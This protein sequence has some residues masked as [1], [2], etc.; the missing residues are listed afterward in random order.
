MAVRA[1][2]D[3]HLGRT[4][5][6]PSGRI[7]F[8]LKHKDVEPFFR[9]PGGGARLIF[10]SIHTPSGGQSALKVPSIGVLS[11]RDPHKK[12]E[13]IILRFGNSDDSNFCRN[14]LSYSIAS[15]S[16]P[17]SL[18]I[19]FGTVGIL[20]LISAFYIAVKRLINSSHHFRDRKLSV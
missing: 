5:N 8:G 12:G 17:S 16:N 4:P 10:R 1:R 19:V 13:S 20:S 18:L 6:L 14:T 3:K 2:G 11:G 15:I 7:F 9:A